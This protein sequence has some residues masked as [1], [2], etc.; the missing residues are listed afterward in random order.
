MRTINLPAH[1]DRAAV[2]ALLPEIIHAIDAGDLL[3][4]GGAVTR[5]GQSLLQLLLSARATA[6]AQNRA[7]T[8][9]A[10]EALRGCAQLAG[11]ESLCAIEAAA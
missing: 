2:A 5:A 11:V 10:S 4:D 1:C 3:I 8:I 6:E 9:S 7:F